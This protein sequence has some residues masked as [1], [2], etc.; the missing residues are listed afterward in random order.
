[1]TTLGFSETWILNIMKIVGNI[2]M[3]TLLYG[4][5]VSWSFP[6]RELYLE[7]AMSPYLFFI[8]LEMFLKA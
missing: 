2:S 7:E 4:R 5:E 6:Q 8:I 3:S 1:M